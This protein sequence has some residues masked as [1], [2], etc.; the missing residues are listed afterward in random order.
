M[1]KMD[2]VG[3][4]LGQYRIEALLGVGG[5]G[6]VFRGVHRY[7]DRPA[8]IKV[9]QA[10]LAANPT[11]RARFLVEAKAAAALKHPNIVEIYEFGDQDGNFYLV[12]ELMTDGSLRTLLRRRTSG[13]SWPLALGLDLVRQAAEGL[14]AAHALGMVHR[15]IKPDNL[16]LDR[17]GGTQQEQYLLKI[18]DFGLARLAEGSGLTA[19]GVPMGTLAYMSP[20]QCQ[21]AGK[22]DG[23]S[24]LY[25]LGVVLYEVATGYLPFQIDSFNDALN[26][27][28]NVPPPSPRQQRPDLPLSVEEIILRCLAKRPDER[29]ATGTA[30]ADALE[31][32]R[33]NPAVETLPPL[34]SPQQPLVLPPMSGQTGP[35]LP[36]AGAM[37]AP[38]VSSLPGASTLPRVRVLDQNGQTLQVMEVTNRGLIIGR[39]AGSDIVLQA[40]GISRQH[41]RVTWDGRQVSVTDLGSSNGT[42]L[43]DERLSPQ[44]GHIWQPREVIHLGPFWLR[45]EATA[46]AVEPSIPLILSQQ[47][48]LVPP[49]GTYNPTFIPRGQAAPPSMLSAGR[50]NIRL[51]ADTLTISP[52]QPP[53]AI[54]VTLL[55]TGST[56]DWFTVTTE[57]VPPEW[58]QGPRQEIQL[59]PGMEQSVPLSVGVTRAPHYRAGDYPVTIRARSREKPNE[60]GTTQ[61]LW[62]VL[63]FKEDQMRIEP[64]RVTGKGKASYTLTLRNDGNIPTRYALSGEDDEQSMDYRFGQNEVALE[65]GMETRIPLQVQARRHWLGR[66][67]RQPFLI[68]SL[69]AGSSAPLTATAEFV[70]KAVLPGWVIPVVGAVA[71]ASIAGV[72]VAAFLGVIPG[73]GH[74]SP[75]PTSVVVATATAAPTPTPRPTATVAATATPTPTPSPTATIPPS[76]TATSIQANNVTTVASGLGGAIGSQYVASQNRLYFV[77][78][79]GNL[80]ALDN[81]TG[82]SPNNHV[83]GNG[84]TNPEGI[85]V[86]ADGNTAYITER[87]GD[88]V[89]VSLSSPNR[90]SATVVATG[91]T[92][93][94]QLAVDEANNLAYVIEYANPGSLVKIDLSNGTTT[95]LLTTLQNPVGLLMS[96]DFSTAYITEQ[97]SNG[98]A[99]LSRYNLSTSTGTVIVTGSIP[100]LFFLSWAD[101]NNSAILVAERDP[102]NKVWLVD[103]TQASPSLQLVA[104]LPSAASRPSSAVEVSS[105][106]LFPLLVCSDGVISKLS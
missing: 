48:S 49:V 80:S 45:L 76:P 74:Q 98:T 84:Y 52:G 72:A 36:D 12:M 25:S 23:R 40:Q 51:D 77:E 19:T 5:M 14:A 29:F 67:Q 37:P 4:T 53:T 24:D 18:S 66:E 102:A 65:P 42:L 106:H 30:L 1:N 93:P 64:R 17:L 94:Q 13:Q 61:A 59:N 38:V 41:L 3:Q 90:S 97:L 21:S 44:V 87:S 6:Q 96:P 8:A 39:Q 69:P 85:Y 70:N 83:L 99:H 79:N 105:G 2:W 86:T 56:V 47:G 62:T 88:L 55:N 28:L 9:M 35:Q 60:S 68:H 57:G 15:D 46:A 16:L 100:A 104:S 10:N 95:P 89:K 54:K 33:G 71:A 63:P 103:L 58:V 32:A 34:R 20:E 81:P 7:L 91:L 101:T 92:A 50:V 22:L 73:L 43:G 82:G 26:K 31:R 75:T 78:Y 11:F 27:H